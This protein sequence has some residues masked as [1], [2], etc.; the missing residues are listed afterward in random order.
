MPRARR[1]RA[2]PAPWPRT[3]PAPAAGAG[4]NGCTF[5]S[6][7]ES[8]YRF[9]IDPQPYA[10]LVLQNGSGHAHGTDTVLLQQRSDFL[11]SSPALIIVHVTDEDDCSVR[12][13]G[14]YYVVL[15]GQSPP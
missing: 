5:E 8:M 12:D 2:T 7:L 4:E 1:G 13:G 14:Q 15:Q 6:T 9:L 3:S 10:S 11:R